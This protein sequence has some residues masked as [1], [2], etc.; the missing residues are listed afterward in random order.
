[1]EKARVLIV[2]DA[3]M[4]RKLIS[5][6]L[7]EDS[8]IEVVGTASNGRL[9]LKKIEQLEPDLIVLDVEMPELDGLE[10]LRELRKSGSRVKVIMFSTLTEKGAKT[11][12]EALS[13]GASDYVAKPAN[14]G[15]VLASQEAL[16]TEL[17]PKVKTLCGIKSKTAR[18][19]VTGTAT[20]QSVALRK[21]SVAT[22][23]IDVV[24]IGI[25]TGGPNALEKV[26]P[27]LPKDFTVPVLITQHMPPIFTKSLADRLNSHS[28]VT[29]VEAEDRMKIEK[30]HVYIAPG[31]FH[32]YAKREGTST[33][34]RTSSDEPENSCRPAVDFMFRQ[35]LPAYGA[36][37]LAVVMTGMGQDGGIGAE[38]VVEAGGTVYIQ[39]QASSVVW[40]MPG[41]IANRGV[42]EK[43]LPLEDIAGAIVQR[44]NSRRI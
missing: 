29:V 5:D 21:P 26:V 44:V 41:F 30:G 1:M 17:I 9:A 16:R 33:V 6:T 8:Q 13:L 32:I 25:S 23:R 22:Q 14:V 31:G 18:G 7:G 34:I 2:D 36:N 38:Q 15:G 4:V 24:M 12:I 43:V 39:D 27:A 11:T 10:T 37:I 3:L 35:S 40:G 20:S 19:S 42:A 28:D